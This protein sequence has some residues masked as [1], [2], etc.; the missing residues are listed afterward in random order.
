MSR[1]GGDQHITVS[2]SRRRN[3]PAAYAGGQRRDEC[4]IT[5][6]IGPS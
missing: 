4:P 6:P 2:A 5:L 3:Q 1:Q